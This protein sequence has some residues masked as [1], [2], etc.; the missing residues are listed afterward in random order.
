VAAECFDQVVDFR[1]EV[2][3][4]Y[5]VMI[6]AHNALSIRRRGSSN[7][8]KKLPVRS[9]GMPISRSPAGVD[10][11]FGRCPFRNAER[12]GVCS[13]GAAPITPVSSASISSWS[14]AARMSRIAV[15]N[16]ASVPARRAARSDRANSW[17]VIVR[18]FSVASA[19]SRIAR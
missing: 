1:V 16:V 17:L 13:P 12:A 6:T 14:A 3:V 19:L 7:S 8:G 5:A 4:M 2:P 9:F 11:S 18:S 15:V 10:N